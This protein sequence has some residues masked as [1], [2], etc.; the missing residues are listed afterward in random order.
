M[1]IF[2]RWVFRNTERLLRNGEDGVI[3][4][5]VARSITFAT[6]AP[7]SAAQIGLTFDW[8]VEVMCCDILKENWAR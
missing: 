1:P 6:N 5:A 8:N 4:D 2:E 3:L 7:R